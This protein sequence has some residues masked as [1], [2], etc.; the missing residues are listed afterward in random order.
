[1]RMGLCGGMGIGRGEGG[2]LVGGGRGGRSGRLGFVSAFVSWELQM[3]RVERISTC[4]KLEAPFCL[5]VTFN[6]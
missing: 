4:I 1:M 2:S 3:E 5:E 6:V